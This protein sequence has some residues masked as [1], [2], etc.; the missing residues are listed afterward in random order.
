M[1]YYFDGEQLKKARE[2]RNLTQVDVARKLNT[3]QQ[4]ISRHEQGGLLPSIEYLIIY[5]IIYDIS[6]DEIVFGRK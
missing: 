3:H 2:K 5:S 4:I 1:G 6:L